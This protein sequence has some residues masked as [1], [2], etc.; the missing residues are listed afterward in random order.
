METELRE[1]LESIKQQLINSKR[2][3]TVNELVKYTSYSKSHIYKLTSGNLIPYSK[4]NGKTIF[5]DKDKI[6]VWLLNNSYSSVNYS[7]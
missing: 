6:D 4:P 7:N 5:F 3:L 1:A 2:I